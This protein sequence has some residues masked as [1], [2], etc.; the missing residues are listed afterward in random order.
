MKHLSR[1]EL[2][3]SLEQNLPLAREA[4]LDACV[5]CRAERGSLQ[6]VLTRVASVD[7]PEPSPL[8][9]DHFS[10]RVREQVAQ[11]PQPVPSAWPA[12]V[13][14]L[15]GSEPVPGLGAGWN[16]RGWPRLI[17]GAATLLVCV[18]LGWAG[19]RDYHGGRV[20]FGGAPVADRHATLSLPGPDISLSD[21]TPDEDWNLVVSMAEDVTVEDADEPALA[22]RPG[23]ADRVMTD[24]SSEQRS[25]LA[26]LL[27]AEMMRPAS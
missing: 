23:A 13:T 7:V 25:E 6:Q 27:T 2:I 5:T 8:F 11:Q 18:T 1:E 20:V 19:W 10:A 24:L 12:W 16:A 14:R 4:H 9:W 3:D 17:V 22:V 15:F 21:A 26:R